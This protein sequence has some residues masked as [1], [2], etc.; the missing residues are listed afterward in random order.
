MCSFSVVRMRHGKLSKP[1]FSVTRNC[2]GEGVLMVLLG[3]HWSAMLLQPWVPSKAHPASVWWFRHLCSKMWPNFRLAK[4][5]Q[6]WPVWN[7]AF[8][9]SFPASLPAVPDTSC[10]QPANRRALALG[11]TCAI[12]YLDFLA[13]VLSNGSNRLKKVQQ[14][15]SLSQCS[16]GQSVISISM[17][18]LHLQNADPLVHRGCNEVQ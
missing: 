18:N 14:T 2:C 13:G 16:K 10:L 9:P 3:I 15:S 8:F 17:P 6:H 4:G 1:V 12:T 7:K 11:A 5:S